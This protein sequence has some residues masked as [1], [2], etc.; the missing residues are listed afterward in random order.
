MA[1]QF[2]RWTRIPIVSLRLSNVMEPHD[3]ARFPTFWNDATLRSW[4]CWGY[5][6]ARDSA[7]AFRLSL[8]K[9][10][11]GHEA[12]IIAASDTVMNR[13]S[14]DLLKEVYPQT[15]LRREIGE[16]ETLLSI[17][18]ARRFLGFEPKYSWRGEQ[19]VVV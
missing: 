2:S 6:D 19:R 7:Q 9:P 12:F 13:P 1:D 5:I 8:E 18:K 11:T 3:Y 4:N 16:F 10:I 14:R 17:D 15:P